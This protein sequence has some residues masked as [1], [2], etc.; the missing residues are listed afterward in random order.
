MHSSS[1]FARPISFLSSLPGACLQAISHKEV[2]VRL[3]VSR[4]SQHTIEIHLWNKLELRHSDKENSNSLS[5][6]NSIRA[7]TY[8]F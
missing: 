8:H 4:K 1:H 7:K 2:K 6:K 3:T 5:F